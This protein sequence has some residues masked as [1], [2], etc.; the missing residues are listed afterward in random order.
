[1]K[2]KAIFILIGVLLIAG[3][4][5]NAPPARAIIR[6]QTV[7]TIAEKDTYVSS[8]EDT[9]NFGSED[10]TIA[11]AI[12]SVYDAE[13]YFF[14][15]FSD[16]PINYTKAEISLYCGYSSVPRNLTICLIEEEWEEYSMI[17]LT[18]PSKGI[19]ITTL[20]IDRIGIFKFDVSN[21]IAGRNNLSICAYVKPQYKVDQNVVIISREGYFS[22]A[23]APQLI[24]TYPENAEIT[25]TEPIS[26]TV[27]LDSHSYSIEWTNIGIIEDVKIQ[28]YKST[29]LIE[30]ITSTSTENDGQYSYYVSATR[31]YN[32]TDYRIRISD[33]EDPN[34]YN[35]SAYFSI[36]VGSGTI[37][38]TNPTASDSWFAGSTHGVSWTTTGTIINVD[39]EI[40]KGDTLVSNEDEVSNT[41][42]WRWDIDENSQPGT[43]WRIKILNSDNSSQYDWSEYFEI[44]SPLGPAIPGYNYY[45]IFSLIFII[46]AVIIRKIKK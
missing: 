2:K 27:W 26:S 23:S 24:W 39:I 9:T 46:T 25:I 20:L 14:F 41:G 29:T 44:K 13:A 1:M 31:H 30:N 35:F 7:S 11:G 19:E 18:K 5:F 45:V 10:H 32:G 33:Y 40:Y 42:Y 38:V 43:D 21:Y 8:Y 15:T 22:D 16:Q 12:L 34:V 17:W 37:T 36:N 3:F 4:T 28:L 6:D